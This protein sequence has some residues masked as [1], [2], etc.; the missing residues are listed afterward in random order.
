VTARIEHLQAKTEASRA[1]RLA[2][3]SRVTVIRAR[4]ETETSDV[5]W[6]ADRSLP[7][8]PA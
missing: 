7:L 3:I 4:V 2:G 8:D 1:R 6:P 5:D